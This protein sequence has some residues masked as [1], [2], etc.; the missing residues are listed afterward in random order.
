MS[1][2]ID[3]ISSM[4]SATPDDPFLRFALAKEYEKL[5]NDTQALETYQW[6]VDHAPDYN[7]TYYHYGQ[8]LL[9]REETDKARVILELGLRVTREQGDMHAHGELRTLYDDWFDE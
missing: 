9:Q 3:R 4:L 5:E 2:R 8:L 1:E 7:G 6:L